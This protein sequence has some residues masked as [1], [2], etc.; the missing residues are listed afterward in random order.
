MNG[1]QNHVATLYQSA[2]TKFE[3]NIYAIT[4]PSKMRYTAHDLYGEDNVHDIAQIL[5]NRILAAKGLD[6]NSTTDIA[7]L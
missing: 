6:P 1:K 7:S 2:V 4:I 3:I 5:H